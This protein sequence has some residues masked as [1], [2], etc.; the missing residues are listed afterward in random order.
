[1][2][3]VVP[4]GEGETTVQI[5]VRTPEKLLERIDRCAKETGN[6]RTATV[7]HLLRWALSQYEK[8]RAEEAE[9]SS[10]KKAKS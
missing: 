8:E 3:P 10:K 6:D 5:G 4:E 1:M 9:A 2:R 7:L